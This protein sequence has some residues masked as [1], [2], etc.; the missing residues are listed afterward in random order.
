MN[1]AWFK[2]SHFSVTKGLCTK[3]VWERR[4]GSAGESL[5]NQAPVSNFLVVN[6]GF[7][8]VVPVVTEEN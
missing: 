7:K 3:E 6:V 4:S 5:D 2:N 1:R 8:L